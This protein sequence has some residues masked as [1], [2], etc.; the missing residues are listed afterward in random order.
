MLTFTT[1]IEQ[2]QDYIIST[3]FKQEPVNKERL[4]DFLSK[5]IDFINKTENEENIY[6]WI[7]LCYLELRE[8]SKSIQ[9]FRQ[10]LSI[11]PKDEYSLEFLN[12]V[13]ERESQQR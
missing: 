3:S 9:S 6:Y 12:I 11:N 8:Y 2:Y 4:Q 10:A 5:F 7:G 1:L 13:K